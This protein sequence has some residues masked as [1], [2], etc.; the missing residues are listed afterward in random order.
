[1]KLLTGDCAMVVGF[2]PTHVVDATA[3]LTTGM[4]LTD[5]PFGQA[6][7]GPEFK[8]YIVPASAE[9]PKP[10]REPDSNEIVVIAPANVGRYS[11]TVSLSRLATN[12][13]SEE[14]RKPSQIEPNPMLLT[15]RLVS[16]ETSSSVVLPGPLGLKLTTQ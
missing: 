14:A 3:K 4:A 7:F 15:A 9:L 16:P 11:L 1:M 2:F 8:T 5:P 6:E 12:K 13:A 10:G